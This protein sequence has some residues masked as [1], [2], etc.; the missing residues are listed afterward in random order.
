MSNTTAPFSTS[1]QNV[2]D[3]AIIMSN[4]SIDSAYL[5]IG[6]GAKLQ[7]KDMNQ[8][9]QKLSP[10]L[11]NLEMAHGRGKWLAVYGGDTFVEESPDLGAVM[12]FVK[13]NYEAPLLSIQGWPEVDDFVDYIL[14]YE[15]EKDSTG[16]IL[17]GGVRD[18]IL[19]GGTKIY[20]GPHFRKILTGVINVDARGRIGRAEVAFAREIGINVID[21]LP[22]TPKNGG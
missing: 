4:K 21:V 20:L 12:A 11:D 16:R 9:T 14:R 17:Y 7:Y 15:E 13:K 6:N 8:V 3:V 2:E 19:I 22:L 1:L 10:I 18:G 5:F